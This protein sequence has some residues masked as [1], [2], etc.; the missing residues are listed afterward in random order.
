MG[1]PPKVSIMSRS[2]VDSGST[3]VCTAQRQQSARGEANRVGKNVL[4]DGFSH[5]LGW[6]EQ[7][8]N[9]LYDGQPGHQAEKA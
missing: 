4:V 5:I 6:A 1:T 3:R 8:L 7:V 9:T 2:C